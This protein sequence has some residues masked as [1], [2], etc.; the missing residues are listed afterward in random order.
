MGLIRPLGQEVITLI[1]AGEV[2]QDPASVVKELIENALDAGAQHIDIAIEEGGTRLIR[3]ADDGT[4]MLRED[5]PLSIERYTTSKIRT[6]DDIGDISTYGFRGEALASIAAVADITIVTRHENEEVGTRLVARCGGQT[7][8]EDAARPHGTT[9]TVTNLFRNTPARLKHLD[10]P[11]REGQKV[12]DVVTRHAVIRADVG[13]RLVR[14]GRTVV[15][16]PPGQTPRARVLCLWGREIAGALI[17]VDHTEKGITITGFILRPEVTRGTRDREYF[18][19]CQR[20]VRAPRLS[21]ALETAYSTLLMRGRFPVCALNIEVDRR[22]VDPNV[23]PTKREVRVQDEDTVVEALIRAVRAALGEDR[24]PAEATLLEDAVGAPVET[25]YRP[26]EEAPLFELPVA[27]VRPGL[28]EETVLHDET[29][30]GVDGEVDLFGGAFRIIGQLHRLYLLLEFEDG[31]LVI[32]QHAAHERIVYERLKEQMR[33]GGIAVQEL[34]E[35]IVLHLDARDAE[36][37]L[38]IADVLA[39]VGFSVSSFGGNEVLV[40]TLPEV[41]GR[42]ADESELLA[43]VDRAVALGG[44]AAK[45]Q[46][47]DELV[48]LTAC[49]SAIRAG[50]PMDREEIRELVL[51]LASTPN[52]DH[53]CHGRP[54]MIKV[55]RQELDR[56]FGRDR[57]DALARYYTRMRASRE[58]GTRHGE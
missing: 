43:L 32:D 29:P 15:D 31:L 19:V 18:A 28:T 20:P 10:S 9:V 57:P 51:E 12:H 16:C 48:K 1:S 21:R 33:T 3:V 41:F 4:G 7:H 47:M 14:D 54:S 37:I 50:H 22:R 40:S 2:V 58:A 38:S 56:R 30:R 26:I 17:P 34:L 44:Q 23:H 49:H 13:F 42:R 24:A 36:R 6:P 46:F 8:I 25:P 52:R 5:C 35:P 55:T 53:C 39:E 11:A 27:A 45:E